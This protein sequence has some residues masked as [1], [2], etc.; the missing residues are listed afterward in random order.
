MTKPIPVFVLRHMEDKK[1]IRFRHALFGM[2]VFTSRKAAAAAA[3]AIAHG[4]YQSFTDEAAP[5]LKWRVTRKYGTGW[6][7][8]DRNAGSFLITRVKLEN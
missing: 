2:R 6:T 1:F 8:Q 3:Q 7:A 4:I 5:K